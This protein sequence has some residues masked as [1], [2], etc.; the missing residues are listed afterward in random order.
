[1]LIIVREACDFLGFEMS[2]HRVKLDE[3]SYLGSPDGLAG[4]GEAANWLHWKLIRH[5]S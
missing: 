2:T 4:A 3:E 5:V 1:M